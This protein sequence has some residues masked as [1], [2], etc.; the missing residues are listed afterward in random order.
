MAFSI[1]CVC[2]QTFNV[3]A[4]RAGTQL[5]CSCGRT[6]AV[7]AAVGIAEGG[8]RR[9][10]VLRRGVPRA[11]GERGRGGRRCASRV[12]HDPG[13]GPCHRPA[14][15][16]GS[17]R[18]LRGGFR[19][20]AQVLCPQDRNPAGRQ[21][22]DRLCHV[23]RRPAPDRSADSPGDSATARR[24]RV[25][26]G[27]GRVAPAAGRGRAGQFLLPHD[28]LGRCCRSASA[29]SVSLFPA[30]HQAGRVVRSIADG[31]GG[32]GVRP[33][34]SERC[35]CRPGGTAPASCV[36]FGGAPN[37]G[38]AARRTRS[39]KPP[40]VAPP[41]PAIAPPGTAAAHPRSG[42]SGPR[43][44]AGGT[45]RFDRPVPTV[46][47]AVW[48]AGGVVRAAGGLRPG[49]RGLHGVAGLAARPSRRSTPAARWPAVRPAARRRA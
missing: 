20:D 29:V 38:W 30:V 12:L 14:R 35:C 45:D 11:P 40:R 10:G 32:T 2:G 25:E 22:P 27:T 26:D 46:R 49:D 9:T 23:P 48:P 19:S 18:A 43:L 7:P 13:A 8:G 39:A 42:R 15:A 31:G 6:L 1:R 41:A 34:W 24:G 4:G 5:P 21:R 28:A 16:S 37:A 33:A 17:F 44:H 47:P 3:P 36:R